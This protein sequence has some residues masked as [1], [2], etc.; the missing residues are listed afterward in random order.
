MG[1]QESDAQCSPNGFILKSF[2]L[3]AN[4]PNGEKSII[5]LARLAFASFPDDR[6]QLMSIFKLFD[7]L[8]WPSSYNKGVLSFGY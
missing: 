8:F 1:A 4:K 6:K 3:I 2:Q 5:N 7:K